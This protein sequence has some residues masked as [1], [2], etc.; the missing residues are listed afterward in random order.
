MCF[1]K[2][3]NVLFHRRT[4][5]KKFRKQRSRIHPLNAVKDIPAQPLDAD[6]CDRTDV[7]T[8]AATDTAAATAKHMIDDN[9]AGEQL[10][11]TAIA[12]M[13]AFNYSF[14]LLYSSLYKYSKYKYFL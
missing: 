11:E 9:G 1:Y 12:T 4:K 3:E 2:C 13:F 5:R 10:A 8:A 6:S 14:F 7:C